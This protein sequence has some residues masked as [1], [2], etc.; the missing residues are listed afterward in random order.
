MCPLEPATTNESRK[1]PN[2]GVDDQENPNVTLTE[3][4]ARVAENEKRDLASEADLEEARELTGETVDGVDHP[5]AES[6]DSSPSPEEA[7]I[8]EQR[9]PAG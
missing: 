4:G 5:E 9:P 2:R 1:L 3:Q 6:A 8:R 7:A